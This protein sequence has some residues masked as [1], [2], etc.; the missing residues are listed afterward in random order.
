MIELPPIYNTTDDTIAVMLKLQQN[1]E[2]KK[3]QDNY[4]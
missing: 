3:I 2:L 1:G 4:Q